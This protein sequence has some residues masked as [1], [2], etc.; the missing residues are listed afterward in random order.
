GRIACVEYM[1]ANIPAAPRR[2][3]ASAARGWAG[4]AIPASLPTARVPAPPAW[5]TTGRPVSSHAHRHPHAHGRGHAHGDGH[6]HDHGHSHGLVHDSIKRSREGVRAVSLALG[7]LAL[8][9]AVQA[10]V[11]LLSGSVALL[12]DLVHNAGDALTAIPLGIAFL[13]RSPR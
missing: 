2:K 1:T 8:T 7:V 11:F 3:P 12:A 5:G 9:T 4:R 6:A 10:V 13:M